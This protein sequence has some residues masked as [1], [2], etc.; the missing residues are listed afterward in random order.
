MK[1][2]IVHVSVDAESEVRAK[3][4]LKHCIEAGA[5]T[6]CLNAEREE[7]AVVLDEVDEVEG[8]QQSKAEH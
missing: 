4:I 2:F 3:M 5:V 7:V 6:G 1:T 8:R